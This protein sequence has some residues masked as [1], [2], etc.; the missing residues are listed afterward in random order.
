MDTH[1]E[2]GS[3]SSRNFKASEFISVNYDALG[4]IGQRAKHLAVIP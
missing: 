3:M 1:T 2:F 4:K